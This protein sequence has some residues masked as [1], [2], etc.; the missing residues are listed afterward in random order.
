MPVPSLLAAGLSL[1]VLLSLGIVT[2]SNYQMARQA[3]ASR[4]ASATTTTTT[5]TTTA[6][7]TT[8]ATLVGGQRRRGEGTE[9][10]ETEGRF[11]GTKT[12]A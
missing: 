10:G 4:S 11:F 7:T 3:A 1:L 5:T 12:G 9:R 2:F 8:A 6:T